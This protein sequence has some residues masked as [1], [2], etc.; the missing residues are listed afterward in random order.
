MNQFAR[1][2]GILSGDVPYQMIVAK[3]N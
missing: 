1:D 3:A 2:V